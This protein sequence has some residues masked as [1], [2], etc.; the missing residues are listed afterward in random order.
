MNK[1]KNKIRSANGEGKP[2]V[3]FVCVHN[4]CRSQIA[5]CLGKLLAKDIFDSYSAGTEVKNKIN[6]D[7][8]RLVKKLYGTDMEKTQYCKLLSDI[9]EPDVVI[10]M[11]CNVICPTLPSQYSENWNLEDPTGK[12]DKEFEQIIHLIEKKILEVK[13][14]LQ[15]R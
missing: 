2:K 8:V 11:G 5:E 7:A 10:L 1:Q 4:S 15:E 3:A 12:S 13:D 14:K 9:P 6:P